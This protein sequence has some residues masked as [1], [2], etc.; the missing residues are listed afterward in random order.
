METTQFL[1]ISKLPRNAQTALK[2]IYNLLLNKKEGRNGNKFEFIIKN[3]LKV[4]KI[5]ISSRDELHER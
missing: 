3:P 2:E 5:I 1:D 4:D